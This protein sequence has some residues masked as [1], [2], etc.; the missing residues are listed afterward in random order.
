[1]LHSR[2]RKSRGCGRCACTS[3]LRTADYAHLAAS[4]LLHVMLYAVFP[5][6]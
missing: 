3:D 6:E 2:S 5:H 4:V 1:M